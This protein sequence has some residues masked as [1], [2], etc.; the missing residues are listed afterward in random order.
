MAGQQGTA[1]EPLTD[2]DGAMPIVDKIRVVLSNEEIAR[3]DKGKLVKASGVKAEI[4]LPSGKAGVQTPTETFF[5]ANVGE[6]LQFLAA[7]S[8]D[9]TIAE[10]GDR[11]R[12]GSPAETNGK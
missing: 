11:I 8:K 2:P 1:A 6:V 9:R 12:A 4:F 10:Y 5:G 7:E 3:V